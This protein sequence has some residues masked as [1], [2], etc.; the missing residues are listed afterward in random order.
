MNLEDFLSALDVGNVDVDLSVESARTHK[1]RIENVRTV[2]RRHDDNRAACFETVHLNEE[3]IEGL[4]SFVVAAAQAR[5]SLTSD[6]VDFVDEDDARHVL[7]RLLEQ[8]S[9][10][11]CA[12]AYEHLNEVR[13]AD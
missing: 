8:I 5:A 2:G 6:R 1:S 10:A 7:L 3:L 13:T 9:D 12:H 4:F 11:R